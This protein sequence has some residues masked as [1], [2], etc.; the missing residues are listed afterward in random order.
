MTTTV[1]MNHIVIASAIHSSAM[2]NRLSLKVSTK[3]R[4]TRAVGRT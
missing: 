4:R 3:P 1:A 2:T